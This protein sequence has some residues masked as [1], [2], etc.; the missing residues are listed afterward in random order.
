MQTFLLTDGEFTGMIRALRSLSGSPRIVGFVSS[1][2]SAHRSMLD[3]SYEAPDR[4]DG[5]Y[6]SF[7]IDV[8]RKERVDYVFPVVT[9]SLEYMAAVA[10]DVRRD[11]G[12][13]VVTSSPEAVRIANNKGLLFDYF[14][15]SEHSGI[16]TDYERVTTVGGLRA[17]AAAFHDRGIACVS[18]PV[19]GENAEG[20][21]LFTDSH[22]YARKALEGLSGKLFCIDSLSFL[23]DD[24]PL[25]QER[26]VMPFLPGTEW[27]V[28]ILSD[29]GHILAATVRRNNDMFG[30]LSASTTSEDNPL[31]LEHCRYIAAKLGLSY[32]SCISFREDAYGNPMLLEINPRAMGSIYFSTL[33]GNDLLCQLMSLISRQEQGC[34]DT[35]AAV[36]SPRV[37]APGNTASLYYDIIPVSTGASDEDPECSYCPEKHV[38]NWNR[39][40][41]PDYSVY[42]KYYSRMTS[43]IT[44]IVFNCRFAWD[45]MYHF[46][47]SVI[48]DCFVQI[49]F[50]SGHADPFMMMPL[51]S[52][53]KEKLEKIICA[54]YPEFKKRNIEM[55]IYGIGEEYVE[56]FESISI[57]HEPVFYNDDFSDYL[58]DASALRDLAGRKY[59]KKR[60]HLHN[61]E[62]NFPDYR[63]ETLTEKHFEGCLELVRKWEKEKGVDIENPEESD[64]LMIRNLLAHWHK[65]NARGGV[66]IIDGRIAAFSIGSM[67]KDTAYIHFEKADISY[68]GIYAAINKLIQQHEFPEAVYVNREEDMGIPGLRASKESYFPV[69]KVRKYKMRITM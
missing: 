23:S 36:S 59:S 8:I 33:S 21:L 65:L 41:P 10:E 2:F 57:P 31:L 7:L 34:S 38:V 54:V 58:Y 66:I 45:I 68:D 17:A 37:T 53:N 42:E 48:E 39:I 1:A 60:N 4:T 46:V 55:I 44:D 15:S 29:R 69:S 6:Y 16:I 64:Y 52:L 26:I 24:T 49:S 56:L 22:N 9:S 13:F 3:A 35:A 61:F 20:L 43:R 18:K 32:L 62:K 27:D 25:P 12:A 51:G 40:S 5:N 67:E 47:W 30:G 14:K 50:G 63:Y 11:T 28:D 19:I